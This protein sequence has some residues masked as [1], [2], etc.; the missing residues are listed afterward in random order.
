MYVYEHDDVCED[1][2]GSE[3]C[4]R[5]VVVVNQESQGVSR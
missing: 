3:T 5:G 1:V 2:L 4:D